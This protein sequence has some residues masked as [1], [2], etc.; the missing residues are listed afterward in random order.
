MLFE[1]IVIVS[2][3]SIVGFIILAVRVGWIKVEVVFKKDV[4][5]LC[6]KKDK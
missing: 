1:W 2:G 3:L 4:D 6:G 5:A